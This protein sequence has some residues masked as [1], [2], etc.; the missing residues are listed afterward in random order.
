[1]LLVSAILLGGI[2]F[3]AMRRQSVSGRQLLVEIADL[4]NRNEVTALPSYTQ[5]RAELLRRLRESA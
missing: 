4:D 1:M 3:L 2:F 5:Q